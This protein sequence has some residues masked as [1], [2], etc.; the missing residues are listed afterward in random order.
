M[1]WKYT[2]CPSWS[3]PPVGQWRR[4]FAVM[5]V[6]CED[7]WIWLEWYW[8]RSRAGGFYH[9]RQLK[10]PTLNHHWTP[11]AEPPK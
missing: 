11:T 1:R 4:R 7:S 3:D 6:I 9:E 2:P 10:K 5:P 8:G